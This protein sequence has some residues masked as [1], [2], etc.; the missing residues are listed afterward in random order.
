M[1]LRH[2]I[3]LR[4]AELRERLWLATGLKYEFEGIPI[5]VDVS[6]EKRVEAL[7]DDLGETL[8]LILQYHPLRFRQVRR[9]LAQIWIRPLIHR[10][11]YRQHPG[12]CVLEPRFVEEFPPQSIAASIVHE[13]M[14]ARIGK[15]RLR[16][17][18]E[19][20]NRVERICRRAEWYLGRRI[21]DGQGV[22]ERAEEGMRPEY[23]ALPLTDLV[24]VAYLTRCAEVDARGWPRWLGDWMKRR[25]RKRYGYTGDRD[26]LS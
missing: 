21:P 2:R 18:Q 16:L 19:G 6:F 25:Y 13:A 12:A 5:V 3:G 24:E 11:E 23:G 8:N 9:D 1:K 7:M 14:H 15:R 17:D 22:I 4:I 10:A 26:G 20:W